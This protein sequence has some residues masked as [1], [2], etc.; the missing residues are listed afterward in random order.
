MVGNVVWVLVLLGV[1]VGQGYQL[2]RYR[3]SEKFG[4][5]I[6]DFPS[7]SFKK[8]DFFDPGE[9]YNSQNQHIPEQ[10]SGRR[11]HPKSSSR[12]ASRIDKIEKDINLLMRDMANS[13]PSRRMCVT[14]VFIRPENDDNSKFKLVILNGRDEVISR[15]T[16]SL[17]WEN[18]IL[19]GRDE[20]AA[21]RGT[22]FGISRKGKIGILLSITQPN[23]E[24]N[25]EAPSRGSIVTDYLSSEDSGESFVDKLSKKCENYNGFQFLAFDRNPKG[26]FELTTL[27]HKY[28]DEVKPRRWTSEKGVLGFGNSPPEKPYKKVVRGTELFGKSIEKVKNLSS[29]DQVFEELM[30][31]AKD[32]TP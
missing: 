32:K 20:Q 3:P 12:F 19:C 10:F 15:K 16:S 8:L 2:P 4:S 27:V 1:V 11:Y 25:P 28:V 5:M 29:E 31:I 17:A 14:F 18:D 24:K 13:F 21:D 30:K 22:W 6:S 23:S 9:F 7:S 26:D